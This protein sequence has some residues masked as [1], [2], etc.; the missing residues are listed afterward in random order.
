MTPKNSK[1]SCKL[2]KAAILRGDGTGIRAWAEDRTGVK[3]DSVLRV[4]LSAKELG[5]A[6][7]RET[8]ELVDGRGSRLR[9][10]AKAQDIERR[11]PEIRRGIKRFPS[12][13][14]VLKAFALEDQPSEQVLKEHILSLAYEAEEEAGGPLSD[15]DLV[16]IIT[17]QLRRDLSADRRR[18]REDLLLLAEFAEREA[19]LRRA[20]EAGLPPREFEVYKLF[21]ENPGIKNREVAA[22]LGISVGTVGAFKSR[23]KKTL[24]TA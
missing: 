17:G 8:W 16:R 20:K 18:R 22:R 19:L 3:P 13:D 11:R 12:L 6:T 4:H 15:A 10:T 24:N 21:V 7:P 14:R 9:P 5:E 2:A 23:I 1:R